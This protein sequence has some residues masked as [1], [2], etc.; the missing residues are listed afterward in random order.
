MMKKLF[1][2][3]RKHLNEAA[4]EPGRAVADIEKS[5]DTGEDHM[6]PKELEMEEM[7]DLADKFNVEI[8]FETPDFRD[9]HTYAKVTLQDGGV[10]YYYDSEEMYQDL[11]R[12]H[13]LNEGAELKIPVERYDDFKRKIE[14]WGMLFNKFTG[15]TRDL[16]HQSF[17]RKTDGKRI[18]RMAVELESQFRKIMKEFDF[19]AKSYEDERHAQR[20]KLDRFV[21]DHKFFKEEDDLSETKGGRE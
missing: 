15:Y 9:G 10:M 19:D 16:N 12:H 20:Q 18:V 1:E 21:G 4:Y 5:M 8:E 3:W 14:Q 7:R 11:A 17:D 13:E 6:G 2:N